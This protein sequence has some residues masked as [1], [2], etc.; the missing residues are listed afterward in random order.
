MRRVVVEHDTDA[1]ARGVTC[2]GHLQEFDELRATMPLA[3]QPEN[4]AGYQIDAGQQGQGPMADVFM[5]S[6]YGGVLSWG[7]RPVWG[8]ILDDLNTGFLVIGKQGGQN[9]RRG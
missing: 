4:L 7:W 9:R 6:P 5:I 3:N 8:G 2:V 1:C